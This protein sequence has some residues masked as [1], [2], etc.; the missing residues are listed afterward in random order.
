MNK[1]E[2]AA[3][4]GIMGTNF[5]T[6]FSY[7]ASMLVK[8][9]FSE[10][11]HLSTMLHRLLPVAGK[12]PNHIAGW[13]AHYAVGLLFAAVYIEMWETHKIKH[14]IKNGIIMGAL[15]GAIA[16]LIWK[17]TFKMHPLPP[18]I[19]YSR[20]YMQLV[21]AH[22]VFAIFSTITYRLIK[23]QEEKNGQFQSSF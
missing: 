19:D 15:S 10:P 1:L 2:K 4:C 17:G 7:A 18:W 21:P 16:V 23:M 20:Y 3:I 12:K 11:E 5:M 6:M 14:T 13:T 8:E 9:D 22:V